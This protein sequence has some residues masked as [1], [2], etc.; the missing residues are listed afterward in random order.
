MSYSFDV[1]TEL[2]EIGIRKRELR[3]AELAGIVYFSATLSLGRGLSLSISTEHMDVVRRAISLIEKL[4]TVEFELSAIEQLPKKTLTYIIKINSD[5]STRIVLDDLGLEIGAG[6]VCRDDI[7]DTLFKTENERKC[8]VRGAFLGGGTIADPQKSYQMEFVTAQQSLAMPLLE[9][10]KNWKI[11]AKGI[12]RK[13]AYVV[14]LKESESIVELL[15]RIGA[16]TSLLE[17]ENIKIM[18]SINNDVNRASNFELANMDRIVASSDENIRCITLIANT[19]GL[20]NLPRNLQEMAELRLSHPD[21]S[22][23]ELAS[24]SGGMTKSG[25]NHRLRKIREIAASISYKEEP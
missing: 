25:I 11:N 10:L 8:F 24:L 13:N 3:R 22:L 23:A 6:I 18:K 2:S 16:V 17:I 20:E 1:K 12:V 5:T 15:T 7:L 14:Y 9:I 19:I 21:E 4:Y